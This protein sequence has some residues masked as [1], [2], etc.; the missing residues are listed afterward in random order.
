MVNAQAEHAG[1]VLSFLLRLT[2]GDHAESEDLLQET[3]LRAWRH[4]DSLP[5]DRSDLRRWLFVV[6]RHVAVDAYRRRQVRPQEVALTDL[7]LA[8]NEDTMEIVLA[9][10]T[11]RSALDEL[12]SDQ[13]ALV[14]QLYVHG[15]PLRQVAALHGIP[16]GTVKSRAHHALIAFKKAAGDTGSRRKPE[17]TASLKTQPTA[18]S[19]RIR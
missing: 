11:V 15:W 5:T 13:R 17:G 18:A 3:M 9:A 10:H 1:P 8:S 16:I 2:K 4:I 12:T 14:V 7:T 6:A 19:P